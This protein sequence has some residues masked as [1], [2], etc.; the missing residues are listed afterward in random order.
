MLHYT[1]LYYT[2]LHCTTLHYTTLHYTQVGPCGME[3]YD[4]K[5]TNWNLPQHSWGKVQTNYTEGQVVDV[6][7]CV[8]NLADH[9]AYT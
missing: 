4:S 3:S 6:A 1:T 5:A 2:I 7:W 9:G 8:S